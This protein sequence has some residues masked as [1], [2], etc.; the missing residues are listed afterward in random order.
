MLY[1]EEKVRKKLKYIYTFASGSRLGFVIC[2]RH[3]IFG[4]KLRSLLVITKVKK[5]KRTNRKVGE[6]GRG[7]E[8]KENF[9]SHSTSFPSGVSISREVKKY[10]SEVGTGRTPPFLCVVALYLLNGIP[11]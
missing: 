1:S 9:T 5:E 4:A 3:E 2:T 10:L 6:G 11:A 8:E 7:G